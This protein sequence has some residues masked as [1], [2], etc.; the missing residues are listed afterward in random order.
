MDYNYLSLLQQIKALQNNNH[1]I[2]S[3]RSKST[4]EL[5]NGSLTLLVDTIKQY[6]TFRCSG[7]AD[8]IYLDPINHQILN[9]SYINGVD[10]SNLISGIAKGYGINITDKGAGI[11]EVAVIDKMFALSTELDEVDKKFDNYTTTEDLETNY[12]TINQLNNV[13]NKFDNYTTT[14]DLEENYLDKSFINTVDEKLKNYPTNVYVDTVFATKNEFY[15]E[16]ARIDETIEGVDNKFI[17]YT[18]TKDL[19]DNYATITKVEEVDNKF[20]NYTTTKDLEENYM[21]KTDIPTP[22]E[23]QFDVVNGFPEYF[24]K[25]NQLVQRTDKL[26]DTDNTTYNILTITPPTEITN[27]IIQSLGKHDV[28]KIV[29]RKNVIY[30]SEG[31]YTKEFIVYI[32]DHKVYCPVITLNKADN[33]C[34][35]DYVYNNYNSFFFACDTTLSFDPFTLY[36]HGELS[37]MYLLSTNSLVA[38]QPTI[39]CDIIEAKNALSLHESDIHY[40]YKPSIITEE[41]IDHIYRAFNSET[42]NYEEKTEQIH[43]YKMVYK[44]PPLNEYDIPINQPFRFT[45]HCFGNTWSLLWDGEKWDGD[46]VSGRSNGKIVNSKLSLRVDKKYNDYGCSGCYIRCK[47]DEWNGKFLDNTNYMRGMFSFGKTRL[48]YK[49]GSIADGNTQRIDIE[50][51]NNVDAYNKDGYDYLP[52]YLRINNSEENVVKELLN[53]L[54]KILLDM[55]FNGAVNRL[56]FRFEEIHKDQNYGYYIDIIGELDSIEKINYYWNYKYPVN[57]R[58]IVLYLR[59]DYTDPIEEVNWDNS[60]NAFDYIIHQQYYEILP[61]PNASTTLYTDY[62]I[63]SSKIITADNITTMRSDLNMVSNTVD[64][65]SYDVKDIRNNVE[66][67]NSQMAEQKQVTDCLQKDVEKNRIIAT[68]ALAFGVAG[69]VGSM[70]SIGMQLGTKGI[71]FAS[72]NGYQFLSCCAAEPAEVEMEGTSLLVGELDLMGTIF[73]RSIVTDITPVLN[74]CNEEYIAI[75]D[76][77][78]DDEARNPKTTACSLYTTIDMCNKFRETLKPVFKKL[79]NRINELTE[80]VTNIDISEKLNDYAP[81]TKLNECVKV[82]DLVREDVIDIFA[83]VD[84]EHHVITF[85]FE[86]NIVNGLI[87][88]KTF[89]KNNEASRQRRFYIKIAEGEIIDYKGV[90]TDTTIDGITIKGLAQS[91]SDR[92]AYMPTAELIMD[93]SERFILINIDENYIIAGVVIEQCTCTRQ[94]VYSTNDFAYIQD[95]EAINKKIDALAEQSHNNDAQTL[96]LQDDFVTVDEVNKV[97]TENYVNKDDMINY[98]DKNYIESNYVKNTDTIDF[99]RKDDLLSYTDS[100]ITKNGV[101]TKEGNWYTINQGFIEN[102]QFSLKYNNVMY[103]FIFTVDSQAPQGTATMYDH[104]IDDTIKLRWTANTKKSRVFLLDANEIILTYELLAF[105]YRAP[106]ELALKSQTEYLQEKITLLEQQLVSLK[107]SFPWLSFYQGFEEVV[108][109]NGYHISKFLC[110]SYDPSLSIFTIYHSLTDLSVS[111]EYLC[112]YCFPGMDTACFRLDIV[113]QR[114]YFN[115]ITGRTKVVAFSNDSQTEFSNILLPYFSSNRTDR[116]KFGNVFKKSAA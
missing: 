82:Y 72:K 54:D 50:R 30:D 70:A 73:N 102:A 67:L 36:K 29:F 17:N 96:S 103:D 84:N 27:Q 11:Y 16:T 83:N 99:R 55:T 105:R 60:T 1:V 69:T 6:F 12:A 25:N 31:K 77:P 58:D 38:K 79:A 111:T 44:L 24:V 114:I 8:P 110:F 49:D 10:V 80:E 107:P 14:V 9:V 89:A 3:N 21:K 41:L 74:W 2:S 63:T 116:I 22:T 43:C 53:K 35:V 76:I 81:L 88:F 18:T 39:K 115:E 23:A 5:S 65:V 104:I 86:D 66:T 48:L 91:E 94:M 113:G 109:L 52:V 59:K 56:S 68:T 61:N 20:D 28:F 42:S 32:D 46:N 34:M 101:F 45:E 100:T 64:V 71:Q 13:D 57:G 33:D 98:Y 26:N 78:V 90:Q 95:I 7:I 19:Q 85:T 47:H 75:P 108:F 4:E 97:L 112:V 62:N 37:I 15:E 40:F 51:Y 92:V 87:I 93:T 106:D